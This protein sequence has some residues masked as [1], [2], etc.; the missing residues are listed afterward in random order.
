MKRL[1]LAVMVIF[2]AAPATGQYASQLAPQSQ[3]RT[4]DI[5]RWWLP[6]HRG[7]AEAQYNL[8]LIYGSGNGITPNLTEAARWYQRAAE[9]GHHQAQ[10]MLG[11][12]YNSGQGVIQSHEQALKWWRLAAE[13]GNADARF[14]L[15]MA[16]WKGE[17]VTQDFDKATALFR[18]MAPAGSSYARSVL[19][20]RSIPPASGQRVR[21]PA[22]PARLE[23][24]RTQSS[25]PGG[26]AFGRYLSAARAGDPNA[27][28]Q[29]GYMYAV[30]QGVARDLVQAHLWTNVAAALLPAG[31]VREASIS[32]RN[33]AAAKMT[34]AQILKA[35]RLARDWLAA[36]HKRQ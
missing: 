24:P 23:P 12:L 13:Q 30:G 19:G 22:R 2:L 33:A 10:A 32:N 29:V 15:G 21:T 28:S 7:D 1:F 14:N 6:A 18:S 20:T 34:P 17:G 9:Q 16:Y 35:Q 11:V 36:Y 26:A 3:P 5:N 4:P 31:K 25:V 8:G 27:Q